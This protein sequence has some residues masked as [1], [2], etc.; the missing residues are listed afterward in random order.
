MTNDKSRAF[1][2]QTDDPH[3]RKNSL[4]QSTAISI[5]LRKNKENKNLGFDDFHH[6]EECVE[7]ILKNNLIITSIDCTDGN[8]TVE[9]EVMKY[10]ELRRIRKE[11]FGKVY[12]FINQAEWEFRRKVAWKN[13]RL[14][15][16]A[17]IG[18]KNGI[19]LGYGYFDRDGELAAY[20][21]NKI[22][23]DGDI[24]IGIVLTKEKY[25]KQGLATGLLYL[26]RLKYPGN[27]I[28]AGT[29]E[30]NIAMINTFEKV[31]F[32]PNEFYDEATGIKTNKIKE[33]VN[34]KHP[35]EKEYLTNSVYYIVESIHKEIMRNVEIFDDF[36]MVYAPRYE[37][38]S[39]ISYEEMGWKNI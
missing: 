22:R 26:M 34:P 37:T 20:I 6:F 38:L 32:V 31:G 30:E 23:L 15:E 12:N 35:T 7:D 13:R 27:R 14:C 4:S 17:R 2:I 5:S 25:R 3:G 33:R 39:G 10:Y 29:F 11:E 36:P 24:E 21:D 16:M 8:V 19:W 9:A 1:K 18:L 28:Y